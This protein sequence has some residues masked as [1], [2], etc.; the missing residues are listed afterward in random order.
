MS[1][2]QTIVILGGGTAGWMTANLLHLQLAKH[3]FKVLVIES[4]EIGIIGVGEGSTPQLKVFFDLLGITEQQW[5][6]QCD[7]TYKY[8]IRFNAWTEHK[9]A[10]NT[11][12]HPF[13][14]STDG[15]SA[16]AFLGATHYLRS[17]QPAA[18]HPDRYFLATYLATANK[19]PKLKNPSTA[20]PAVSYGYH[21]DSYKLGAYLKRHGEDQGIETMSA[22]IAS[23]QAEHG[24]ILS[25]TTTDNTTITAD[26]FFDCSG[27]N[28]I[29][30]QKTL[31]VPFES[32][33]DHLYNDSAIATPTPCQGQELGQTEATA[34]SAG[35]A[36]R[37]PL[38]SRIGNGY[39]F[40][41]HYKSFAEAET[42][43]CEHLGLDP[44]TASFRRIKMR[45]GQVAQH[46][47]G[48]CVGVGLAQGFIEP[49]EATALHLVQ[50]TVTQF[51]GA[52]TAGN[53]TTRHQNQF[54]E[55]I[56]QRFLG[57]KDYIT[58][59][60]VLNQRTDSRYW[61][62]CRSTV[63][64]TPSLNK[65][66]AC[67]ASNGDLQQLLQEQGLAAYYPSISWYCL[68]SGYH[69]YQDSHLAQWQNDNTT[70]Q[71]VARFLREQCALFA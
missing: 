7:A 25:L 17:G 14:A 23:A 50:E 34:L 9:E 4:P 20:P 54:N 32:F 13:P 22:T 11:Y 61:E 58:G 5:M 53:F 65:I 30:L 38:Q 62:D 8:G 10:P 24:N 46:W 19:T 59:H 40:S 69:T 39:V 21:F 36:W 41:S 70:V 68:L 55:V 18:P 28:S 3:G 12:F 57:V 60:Y 43:F 15:H 33:S 26:W 31:H 6:P 37:I 49:L 35:W 16:K 42:E 45:V 44:D 52:F 29:L 71:E 66:M 67:W 63:K 47:S 51:I 64:P 56:K 48:N 27:F 2:Q 1:K